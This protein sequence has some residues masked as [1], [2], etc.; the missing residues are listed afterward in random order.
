M[1]GAIFS[2]ATDMVVLRDEVSSASTEPAPRRRP[3]ESVSAP[4]FAADAVVDDEEPVGVVAALD[5]DE[6]RVVRAPEG[7]LPVLLEIVALVDIGAGVGR[8]ATRS[9]V[10]GGLNAD[11]LRRR[12]PRPRSGPASRGRRGGRGRR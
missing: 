8:G 6:A 9:A 10:I 12:R 5:F 4:G 11:R 1:T 3:S 2:L 7:L